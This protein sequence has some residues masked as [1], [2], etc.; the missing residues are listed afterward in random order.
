MDNQRTIKSKIGLEGIGLHTGK[1]TKLELLPASADTGITFLRKDIKS[2]SLIKA[3]SYSVLDPDEFP[4]RTSVGAN[5]VYVHTVEH[6]MA[7]LYLLGIDNIQINIYKG[8][9]FWIFRKTRKRI[10]YSFQKR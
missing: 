4:R 1:K 10:N 8:I 3:N 5:G 2:P 9:C 6:L 7:A